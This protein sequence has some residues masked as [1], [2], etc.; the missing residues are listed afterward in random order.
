VEEVKTARRIGIMGGSFDPV[1]LGHLVCA[2]EALWQ[3]NLDEVIW[4]PAGNPWQKRHVSSAEDRYMMVVVA[5]GGH[6]AFS[7]SRIE[8]DRSGPTYTIET[9]KAFQQFHGEGAELF[10]ITGADAV[11]QILTW[12]D[13]GEALQ[14][15]HFIAA[16]RPNYELAAPELDK[17]GKRVSVMTIPGL[18]ISSTDIRRRV[19]DGRPIRYLVPEGVADYIYERGLYL[20]LRESA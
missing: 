18:E 1:H 3:F 17:F 7:V 19:A 5:T 12:K 20:E 8:M 16:N 10:F 15:A 2:E 14:V 4:V 13:P 9:L 11:L 6:P